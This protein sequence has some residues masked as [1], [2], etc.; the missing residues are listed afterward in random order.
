MD[1][2]RLYGVQKIIGVTP[3][4]LIVHAVPELVFYERPT[5]ATAFPA[6]KVEQVEALSYVRVS[7]EAFARRKPKLVGMLPLTETEKQKALEK[8]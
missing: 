1:I 3:D 7:Y 8:R 2:P 6:D 5:S 4:A